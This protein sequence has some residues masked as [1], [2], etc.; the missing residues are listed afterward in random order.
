MKKLLTIIPV[1][2]FWLLQM[3]VTDNAAAPQ[4][5]ARKLARTVNKLWKTTDFRIDEMKGVRC[6]RKGRWYAVVS[7]GR[8]LGML[9]NGRVNSCR[10]GGCSID[11]DDKA[12]LSFEYFDY[13]LFTD[14]AGKVLRINIYNYQATH[15]QEVM[16]RGWLNQFKGFSGNRRL[17]FG[18]DVEAISGATVSAMA[19][20]DDIQQVLKCLH[21]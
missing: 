6:E 13:M 11:P 5:P 20:T 1:M 15:G 17:E 18:R 19:I 14:T 2:M 10:Q 21:R 7:E 4:L 8:Q 12:A 3:A 16:S 9:Y